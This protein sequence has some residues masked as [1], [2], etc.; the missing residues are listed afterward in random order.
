MNHPSVHNPEELTGPEDAPEASE[1]PADVLTEVCTT[2]SP[3][4]DFVDSTP[5][6]NVLTDIIEAMSKE[7]SNSVETT[8]PRELDISAESREDSSS[9]RPG[10]R[11]RPKEP[12]ARQ[13]N[14]SADSADNSA[15]VTEVPVK[16][17]VVEDRRPATRPAPVVDPD[18]SSQ[19]LDVPVDKKGVGVVP[20]HSGKD[21]KPADHAG[22]PRP[23]PRVAA[24]P[25]TVV[26]DSAETVDAPGR[27]DLYADSEEV[28][29]TQRRRAGRANPRAGSQGEAAG[30]RGGPE[31]VDVSG[32]QAPGTTGQQHPG[33]QRRR[34]V[35]MDLPLSGTLVLD[36][37]SAETRELLDSQALDAGSREV[38]VAQVSVAQVRS[39]RARSGQ[40]SAITG[41]A[42][43]E[44]R[45]RTS[46]CGL[47][48]T[49]EVT[50]GVPAAADNTTTVRHLDAEA[51]SAEETTALQ[52]QSSPAGPVLSS[53]TADTTADDLDSVES[54][55]A[56]SSERFENYADIFGNT[57]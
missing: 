43:G 30:A 15:D 34:A 12:P 39:P 35:H 57:L 8:D 6:K 14:N 24:A 23:N 55:R 13:E 41:A 52:H 18:V 7:S 42:E 19:E 33:T 32:R 4:D 22:P 49:G 28:A 51:D 16:K 20:G 48:A 21:K 54:L 27:P 46:P 25:L 31:A 5:E 50:T 37:D 11:S 40:L 36:R 1:A 3:E 10:R 26:L 9:R 45:E 29:M 56:N 53:T 38:I 2:P 17:E 44:N 47:C